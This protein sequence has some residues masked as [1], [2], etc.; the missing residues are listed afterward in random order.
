[1]KT[2][3]K[4]IKG[5]EDQFKMALLEAITWEQSLTEEEKVSIPYREARNRVMMRIFKRYKN[6]IIA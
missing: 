2:D 6:K 1:M 4:I 5:K 3:S